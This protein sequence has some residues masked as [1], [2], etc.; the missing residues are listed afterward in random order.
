MSLRRALAWGALVAVAGCAPK[1]WVLPD[2]GGAVDPAPLARRLEAYNRAL[3]DVRVAGKL[4]VAGQGG[5]AFGARVSDGRGLRLDAVAGPLG[6]P[7]FALACNPADGCLAYV[8]SRKRVYRDPGGEWGAWLGALL[9][10]RVPVFGEPARA[11]GEPGGRTVLE[12]DGPDGWTEQV[13]FMAGGGPPTGVRLVLRGRVEAD[14]IL[15][16]PVIVAGQPVP[17]RVT[18]DLRGPGTRYEL[19]LRRIVPAARDAPAGFRLQ[20]PAG[21]RVETVGGDPTW[22]EPG[23]LP[24]FPTPRPP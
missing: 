18:V 1:G 7:V 23:L 20:V 8:P 2:R 19:R 24:R 3:P 4:R 17:T 10:G 9:R 14:V 12:L 13:V 15:E 21:T 11:W 16:E 6:S 5:A 22:T